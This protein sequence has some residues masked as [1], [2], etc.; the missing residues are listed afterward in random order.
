MTTSSVMQPPRAAI[1]VRGRWLHPGAWWLWAI[2]LATAASRTTNPWLLAVILAVAATV[3]AA[4]RP[5]APW[6]R[7]FVVF[8]RIGAIVV[9]VRMVFA[10]LLGT[11][12]GTTVLVTLPSVDLPSW[13]AGVRLGGDITAES[14]V[15]AFYEGLKLATVLACMGAASSLASPYRLL[16]AMPAALYEVGVSL[17]VAL[18]FAPALV[19][20]VERVRT[21]RRLRGRPTS[22]PRGLAGAA[23]PVFSGALER[24]VA[25]AA[26]MDSRGYGRT[27]DLSPRERRVTGWLVLGGIVG[28]CLGVYALL[29]GSSASAAGLP[30]LAIGVVAAAT[31]F[32]RGGRRNV[33]TRYRP[34]PWQ[35]PEWLTAASGMV[36]AAAAIGAGMLAPAVLNPPTTP[37]AWPTV[38]WLAV[39]GALVALTPALATPLPPAPVA[40]RQ[41]PAQQGLA[42]GAGAQT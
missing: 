16:R 4:R 15:M 22:G 11:P 24:S 17:V 21:A 10:V 14:L 40:L 33:R 6:S 39:A 9:L 28:V 18:S 31:G 19:G 13:M 12:Q 30:L 38:P 20:D 2:G 8:L 27:A 26:A 7:S 3:V 29:D 36:A 1:G 35:R 37:L 25:L 41:P 34:D 5:E 32:I 42:S 23:M